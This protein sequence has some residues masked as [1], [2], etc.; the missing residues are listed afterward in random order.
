MAWKNWGAANSRPN[1]AKMPNACRI[2][3]QVNLAD[4]NSVRSTSGC[5]PGRRVSLRSHATNA[6]RMTTPAVIAAIAVAEPQPYCPAA[7]NPY[8]SAARPAHEA[9]MPAG[10][11]PGRSGARD[12]GT[13]S[14]TA[15]MPIATTG[16]FIRNTQPHQ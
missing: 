5:P 11:T 7:M 8:T 6:A 3:P 15:A 4:L 10:S 2:V 1:I 14:A 16:R 13:S 12:S 9:T